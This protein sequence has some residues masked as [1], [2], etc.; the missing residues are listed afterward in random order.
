L[1]NGQSTQITTAIS[2]NPSGLPVEKQGDIIGEL[3]CQQVWD[4][5]MIQKFDNS[6]SFNISDL[7]Y[8]RAYIFPGISS[9]RR[10]NAILIQNKYIDHVVYY[11]GCVFGGVLCLEFGD[12]VLTIVSM[13]CPHSSYSLETLL[14]CLDE[15]T[16]LINTVEIQTLKLLDAK[17]AHTTFKHIVGCDTNVELID[18]DVMCMC[19]CICMC[20]CQ[21]ILRQHTHEL[22]HAAIG[23]IKVS[24]SYAVRESLIGIPTIVAYDLHYVI[25]ACCNQQ[26]KKSLY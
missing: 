13:H 18:D 22:F 2:W 1:Q 26:L 25:K 8:A 5:L 19:M 10:S 24:R 6:T 17:L 23:H 9:F 12:V 3:S 14:Q 20:M 11:D 7:G 16:N 4:F 15:M 21:A